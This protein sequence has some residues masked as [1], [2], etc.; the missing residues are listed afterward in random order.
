VLERAAASTHGGKLLFLDRVVSPEVVVGP[1]IAELARDIADR[2]AGTLSD[3]LR[4]AVPP[5]HARVEAGRPATPRPTPS[6][7]RSTIGAGRGTRPAVAL[8]RALGDGKAPR[9][10]WTALPGEDWP[11]RLAEAAATCLAGG[12]GALVVVA[13]A[14]DLDR[15]DAAL[16]RVLGGPGHHVALCA[17]LGPAERYHRFLSVLRGTARIVVGTRAAAFAPVSGLG[18]VAIWDDGDD[19]H[20]D[21]RAPYP[22]ARQ[23]LLSRAEQTGC[24]RWWEASAVPLKHNSSSRRAGRSR[25]APTATYCGGPCRGWRRPE[26]TS[27]PGSRRPSRPG[28]PRSPGAPPVTRS[29]ATPR[30]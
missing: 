11:A 27:T 22:H 2:Y 24:A 13:D 3:V 25:S 18:L 21:P 15:L 4:L 14:R 16:T 6:W 29:P 7:G 17:A 19:L 28:C 12:R 30:C 8:L 5:R 23:V 26:S 20:A 10:V 1:E 9:A